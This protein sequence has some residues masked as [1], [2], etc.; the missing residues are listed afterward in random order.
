MATGNHRACQVDGCEDPVQARGY[1]PA[2]YQRDR[3]GLD[4]DTP[5]AERAPAGSKICQQ[6]D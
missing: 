4:M 5:I 6:S 3:K 2:H 1:C